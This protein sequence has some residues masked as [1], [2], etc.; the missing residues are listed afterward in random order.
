MNDTRSTTYLPSEPVISQE[1][2]DWKIPLI[3]ILSILLTISVAVN[4]PLVRRCRQYKYHLDNVCFPAA[5]TRRSASSAVSSGS[6]T[7]ELVDLRNDAN[8]ADESQALAQG[9]N[10]DCYVPQIIH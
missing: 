3:V 1:E 9:V 7:F 5:T 10:N 2:L 4:I 6:D 8:E